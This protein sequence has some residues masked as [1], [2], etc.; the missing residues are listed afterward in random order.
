MDGLIH[1]IRHTM[2]WVFVV[3]CCQYGF[4]VVCPM[5]VMIFAADTTYCVRKMDILVRYVS[6]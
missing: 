6:F 4:S 3:S 1:Q 5:Y 2:F